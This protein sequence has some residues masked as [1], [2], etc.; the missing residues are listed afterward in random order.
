MVGASFLGVLASL[1]VVGASLI[2][3]GAPLRVVG[4][5]LPGLLASPWMDDAS[6]FMDVAPLSAD[7][8]RPRFG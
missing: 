6:L 3:T 2:G 8:T 4:A 5:S 1:R 7:G